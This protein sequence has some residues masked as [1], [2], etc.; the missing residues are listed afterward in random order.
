RCQQQAPLPV[1][2]VVHRF[3]CKRAEGGQSAEQSHH[4]RHPHFF[5]RCK[6]LGEEP[7]QQANQEAV[8]QV[9]R[10]RPDRQTTADGEIP[11]EQV[12][13]VPHPRSHCPAHHD[14]HQPLHHALCLRYELPASCTTPLA[15]YHV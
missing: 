14:I 5:T 13:A 10:D 3:P 2:E 15:P 6:S 8:Q 7:P 4:D 12:H 11:R 9:D 1:A